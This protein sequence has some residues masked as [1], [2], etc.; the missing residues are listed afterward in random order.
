MAKGY[1]VARVDVSDAE[2]YKKYI[3]A[4]AEPFAEFGARFLVRAG[5]FEN[6]EG[7]SRSRN[8]VIEF[9]SYEAALA[10]YKSPGYQKAIHLR[11][12]ASDSDLVIVEGYDGPQPGDA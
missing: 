11:R 9:P 10:C 12:N 5:Q 8:V 2:A 7:G 4:N 3:A 1:W 6:P